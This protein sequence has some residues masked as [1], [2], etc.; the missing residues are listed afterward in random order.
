MNA[1]LCFYNATHGLNWNI[2]SIDGCSFEGIICNFEDGQ[3]TVT[4][5]IL[6]NQSLF[7]TIPPCVANLINLHELVLTRNFL[8]GTIPSEIGNSAK[9]DWKIGQF[10]NFDHVLEVEAVT[11]FFCYAEY[12]LFAK[13]KLAEVV[14]DT[15]FSNLSGTIPPEI[16][17]ITNLLFLDL[18]ENEFLFEILECRKGFSLFFKKK[19][20][21]YNTTRD[22][23]TIPSEIGKLTNLTMIILSVN[24]LSE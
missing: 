4:G 22:C 19:I 23:G 21:W 1:L 14:F 2:S 24:Q 6:N 18:D 8:Q 10:A 15:V 7:G 9:G 20:G 17:N 11:F 13:R 5:I 16:G 12:V 3:S